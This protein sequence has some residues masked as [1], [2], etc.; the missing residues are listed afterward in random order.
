LNKLNLRIKEL[1][2]TTFNI[3]DIKPKE[4]DDSGTKV[5]QLYAV[6]TYGVRQNLLSLALPREMSSSN[7]INKLIDQY[8]RTESLIRNPVQR[9]IV[10]PD[11]RPPPGR[12][13]PRALP[14]EA[15]PIVLVTTPV[16]LSSLGEEFDAS[17]YRYEGPPS[18]IPANILSSGSFEQ[19]EKVSFGA[20]TSPL[21]PVSPTGPL[22]SG[23]VQASEETSR[24]I[25]STSRLPAPISDRKSIEP[26]PVV[27][28][29]SISEDVENAPQAVRASPPARKPP[30]LPPKKKA[31]LPN[32]S[33]IRSIRAP[34]PARK[35]PI[36]PP[37][38]EPPP[39]S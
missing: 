12:P 10:L 6:D 23:E 15:E 18:Q 35:P 26:V 9:E 31:P 38:R 29:K 22:G 25:S 7:A 11:F 30:I 8:L 1:G 34:P 20:V 16:A 17:T 27:P 3:N 21:E 39:R 4:E 13:L 5:W 32:T 19:G 33:G 28:K 37:K 14:K 36:L 24:T 2:Y